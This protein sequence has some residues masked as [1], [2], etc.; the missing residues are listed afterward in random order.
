MINF[1]DVIKENI[2]EHNP[3]WTEIL[4][5][6]CRPLI[7]GGSGSGK[8]KAL[9]NVI[10]QRPD[11]DY[12]YLYANDPYEAKHQYLNKPETIGSKHLNDSKAFIEYSNNMDNIHKNVEKYNPNKKT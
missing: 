3:D 6:L 5:H 7:T 2:K 8:T 4:D 1:E 9:F 12:F 10:N 11:I